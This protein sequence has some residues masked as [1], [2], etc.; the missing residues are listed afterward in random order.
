MVIN[1]GF[2]QTPHAEEKKKT[3][4]NYEQVS[5]LSYCGKAAVIA[6]WKSEIYSSTPFILC[7]VLKGD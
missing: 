6:F 1:E 4:K 3:S 5:I 2:I 7:S